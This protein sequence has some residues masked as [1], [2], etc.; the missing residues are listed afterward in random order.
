MPQAKRNLSSPQADRDDGLIY[1]S[2]AIVERRR[3]ILDETRKMIAERGLD[4]F[5]MDELCKRARVAKRTLYNAY[6]TKE[7]MIALAIK[8]YFENFVA[9]IPFTAPV[10]S[11]KRNVDRITF[12]YQ[13]NRN[14]RNYSRALVSIYYNPE[15]DKDILSTMHNM[16]VDANLE[17]IMAYKAKRQLHPWIDADALANDIVR[18]EYALLNDW[19]RGAISDDEIIHHHVRACLTIAAG[20]TRGEARKEIED[21]LQHYHEQGSALPTLQPR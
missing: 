4:G 10:G 13:R 12:I 17:W 9:T 19:C 18:T 6:Q 1:I 2:P 7:R 3:R 20:A 5:N 8:E 11:I 16:T 15:V 14:P 21:L